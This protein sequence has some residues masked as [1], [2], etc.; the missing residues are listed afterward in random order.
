MF[1]RL[2]FFILSHRIG[3]SKIIFFQAIHKDDFP[4]N[5]CINCIEDLCSAYA[6]K[7]RCDDAYKQIKGLL[8]SDK[9]TIVCSDDFNVHDWRSSNSDLL[10]ERHSV[11]IETEDSEETKLCAIETD[12]HSADLTE[13]VKLEPLREEVS[14]KEV[15]DVDG[16]EFFELLDVYEVCLLSPGPIFENLFSK[17]FQRFL[18][19][20]GFPKK[21]LKYD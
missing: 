20:P 11:F 19:F 16:E 1:S 9:D 13:P 12:G 18:D 7:L 15:D 14:V 4:N 2:F 10:N 17:N 6:F 3:F 5:I 21:T 8:Q